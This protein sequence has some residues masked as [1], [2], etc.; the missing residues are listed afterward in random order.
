MKKYTILSAIAIF[1]ALQTSAKV[2]RVNNIVGATSDFTS[3]SAAVA[4]ATVQNNDTI[5][6]EP[7]ATQYTGFNLAKK[8]VFIGNGYFLDGTASGNAGLQENVNDSKISTITLNVGSEGSRFIGL[9]LTSY[10]H[11]N[12]I[13]AT[14]NITIER[15]HFTGANVLYATG[16]KT[17]KNIAM[18]KCFM[19]S[20]YQYY[21]GSTITL[22]NFLI[23]NSV[24][25]AST[26]YNVYLDINAAST[27]VVIRNNTIVGYVSANNAYF[28]NNIFLSTIQST[29]STCVVKNNVFVAPQT[30]ITVGPLS[31]NG[32]NLV[33]QTFTSII[34]NSGSSDGRYQL[35]AGSP[36]IGGGLNIGGVKPDCGAFGG[37]DPYGLSGIPNIPTIYSV[38]FPNGNSVP[39][40][41]TS[42]LVDFS[43][44]NNK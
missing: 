23:E 41:G 11:F 2:W 18:R 39:A 25:A 8:L 21:F 43:T 20:V 33:S 24:F 27:G 12:T 15:C 5:Y 30:G 7:S 3:V 44:R 29:L 16:I 32:N 10:I 4:H 28:A 35:T 36:A 26:S 34:L 13:L 19:S 14:A 40:G 31:T 37:N 1:L 9:T 6:V 38:S 22:D 42:M 17:L